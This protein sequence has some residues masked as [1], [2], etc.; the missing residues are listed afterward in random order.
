MGR[1]DGAT[2]GMEMGRQGAGRQGNMERED[3]LTRVKK[4]GQQEAGWQRGNEGRNLRLVYALQYML[5]CC[6]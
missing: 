2:R 5:N 1:K 4:T 3:S 6:H